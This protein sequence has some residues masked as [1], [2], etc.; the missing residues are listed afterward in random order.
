MAAKETKKVTRSVTA[1]AGGSGRS[2]RRKRRPSYL[3]RS[4]YAGEVGNEPSS[5]LHV[6]TLG[7]PV[8]QQSGRAA[9]QQGSRA[10]GQ[11]QCWEG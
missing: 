11:Q 9:G 8:T 1:H 7:V 6:Q 5:R 3:I 2:A 10:V 4:I